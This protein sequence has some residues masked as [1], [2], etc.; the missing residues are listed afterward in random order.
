MKLST[1]PS[2][3]PATVPCC[4]FCVGFLVLGFRLYVLGF[5]CGTSGFRVWL[6]GFGCR[7]LGVRL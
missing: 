5:G 6:L 7:V 2:D 4:V 3:L 1:C